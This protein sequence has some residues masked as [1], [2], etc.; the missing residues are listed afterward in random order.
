MNLNCIL[1]FKNIVILLLSFTTFVDSYASEDLFIQRKDIQRDESESGQKKY[2]LKLKPSTL[3]RLEKLPGTSKV[4]LTA[5]EEKVKNSKTMQDELDIH[6]RYSQTFLSIEGTEGQGAG[7]ELKSKASPGYHIVW[8]AYRK[9]KLSLDLGNSFSFYDFGKAELRIL[10][11]PKQEMQSF[12]VKGN[13]R[14]SDELT[15]SFELGT[16]K[17]F[18]FRATDIE[19]IEI[20]NVSVPYYQVGVAYEAYRMDRT[21]FKVKGGIRHHLPFETNVFKGSGTGAMASLL[22]DHRTKLLNLSGELFYSRDFFDTTPIEF[23]RAEA[24]LILGLKFNFGDGA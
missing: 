13:Y 15:G 3:K 14:L 16:K 1:S 20:D 9:K 2:I 7:G 17:Q 19:T 23:E 4:Y 8:T 24:G 22:I 18:F 5:R 11:E 12:F 6:F 10:K 21:E